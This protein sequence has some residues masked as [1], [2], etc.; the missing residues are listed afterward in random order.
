MA[1][2][3]YRSSS[4]KMKSVSQSSH[5]VGSLSGPRA[6]TLRIVRDWR[7]RELPDKRA[8]AVTHRPSSA[9]TFVYLAFFYGSGFIP[10]RPCLIVAS[11]AILF[12]QKSLYAIASV[13]SLNI[14][15]FRRCLTFQASVES[16][17]SLFTYVRKYCHD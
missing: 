5:I 1:Y 2:S 7:L 11:W 13:A 15:Q 3:V 14:I 17:D 12:F 10:L 8:K 9:G 6:A 16:G 4:F